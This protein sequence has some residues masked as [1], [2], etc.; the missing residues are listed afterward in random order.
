MPETDATPG[1]NKTS[2]DVTGY[3]FRIIDEKKEILCG[4]P[5]VSEK[6]VRNDFGLF[7]IALCVGCTREHTKF[8][9]ERRLR[10]R[11]ARRH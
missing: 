11:R 4:K 2:T 10:I 7:C 5:A 9:E 6:L 1:V 8:Y 3:C